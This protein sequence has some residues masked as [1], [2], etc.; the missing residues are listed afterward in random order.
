MKTRAGLF[1]AVGE[2][3]EVVE[4]DL[5]EPGPDDVVVRMAAVGICGTDLHQVKGEW[6]RPTPM[7]LGHEGAGIVEAVGR[8]G[9]ARCAWAT[10]S[11]SPGRPPAGSAPTAPEG[12]RRRACRS[13]AR[14]GTGRSSTARRACR[15]AARR[16]TAARRRA[17]GPS[18]SSSPRRWRC[19][20]AARCRCG[21][22]RCSGAP[23]SRASARCCSRRAQSREA[24]PSSSA[25]AASASSS[26]RARAS[27]APRRSS[28]PIPVEARREQ[29][30]R[31]GA[32]HAVHPD[33]LKEALKEI[34]PG[35]RRLRLRRGRLPRDERN[36]AP[37]HAQRRYDGDGRAAADRAPPRSRPG[38][39]PPPR[40]VPHRDDVRLRGPG[41]RAADPARPCRGRA[42][43]ARLAA[44]GDVPARADRR[45]GAGEPRAARGAGAGRAVSC[46]RVAATAPPTAPRPPAP[47]AS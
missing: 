40:E 29:A 35:G 4:L 47:A 25:P 10:R 5:A 3:L 17:P 18:M 16:C 41:R 42:A 31:L 22:R 19:R 15:S 13:T 34:A 1:R 2:P 27:P 7:V 9:D 43:R 38:R 24:S 46:R 36:R 45:G 28:S 8:R 12:A 26:S 44:R 20:R 21:T 6:Q 23:R 32:T 33:E 30:L 11:S 14:S 37:L 39:V